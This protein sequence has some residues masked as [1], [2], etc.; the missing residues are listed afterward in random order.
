MAKYYRQKLQ[1]I[2]Y[3]RKL[4]KFTDILGL[5]RQNRSEWL[6]LHYSVLIA[7]LIMN[8][9]GISYIFWAGFFLGAAGLHRLYNGK[10]GTGLLWLCTGGLFGVGQFIDVFFVPSMAEEFESKA[11]ARLGM[12]NAGVPVYVPQG[13]IALNVPPQKTKDQLMVDLV[14]AAY[15]NGGRLSV[16]QGVMATGATFPEVEKTLKEMLKTGYVS[17][18]NDPQTGVVVYEFL[19]LG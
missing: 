13:A 9:V 19:E 4:E 6:N 2:R 14:K 3:V 8:R 7:V 16:T 11:K 12:G 5:I 17:I 1:I 18:G 15:A 10:I